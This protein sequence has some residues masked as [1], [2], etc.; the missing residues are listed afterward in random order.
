[1]PVKSTVTVKQNAGY[2][3]VTLPVM[4]LG[5]GTIKAIKVAFKHKSTAGKML[6]DDASLIHTPGG[7]RRSSGV[8]PPPLA[9][10][11]FRGGN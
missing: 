11:G 2:T 7:G 9:P 6:V 5:A 3:Q 4:P 8:L 10:S 1:V